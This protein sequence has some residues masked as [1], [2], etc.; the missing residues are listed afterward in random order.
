MTEPSA[1]KTASVLLIGGPDAGKSNFLFRVW[2]AIDA[3]RGSLAKDGLPDEVAYLRTGAE[4]LM[5]GSFAGRTS[6]EVL[7][8]VSI[9]VKSNRTPGLSGLL[10]VPD[11]PG[12]R[13]LEVYRLRHWDEGWERRID[14]GCGCLLFVR[15]GSTET[16]PS[17][18]YTAC[19]AALGAPLR[20]DHAAVGVG[21][22]AIVPSPEEE[23]PPPTDVV[24]TDWLQFIRRAFTDR[25][26]GSYRPRVGIAI[27][28]W[29]AVPQ[30]MQGRDPTEFFA[31]EFPLTY[32]F[33]SANADRFNFQFFGVSVLSGDVEHDPDFKAEFARGSPWD[34]GYVIHSLD[35]TVK[36]DPDV[37]V[38]VAWA[39]GWHPGAGAP[40]AGG[41]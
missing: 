36:R 5:S 18:D 38:A 39:L 27:A 24:L 19:V 7:E 17:L 21:G 33:V 22:A 40:E 15:A 32:Q 9:P 16:I 41:R 23:P 4:S 14:P 1:D 6:G 20:A 26:G 30:D 11:V 34:F 10:G 12:E 29:D 25:V 28:A 3:G 37:T 31:Q 2:M 8:Q 35:G 13:V